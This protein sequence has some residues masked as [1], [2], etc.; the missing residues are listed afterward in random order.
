MIDELQALRLRGYTLLVIIGWACAAWMLILGAL[1]KSPDTL[2]A[3]LM[4]VAA[5][6][7]PTLMWRQRRVDSQARMAI[8]T[9][10]AIHPALA[11]WLWSGHAFQMDTHMYFFVALSALAVLC[12]WRPIALASAMIALHHAFFAI[13]APDVVFTADSSIWR[14]LVHAVA[15][16]LELA[17]LSYITTRMRQ[18]FAQQHEAR[19]QS[20]ALAAEA[21]ARRRDLERAME[22]ARAAGARAADERAR[23]EQVEAEARARHREDLHALAEAFSASVAEVVTSVGAAASQLEGSARSLNTLALETSRQTAQTARTAGSTAGNVSQLADQV[24]AISVSITAI[25]AAVEQQAQLSGTASDV[26]Q[27]G[28]DTVRAL[29]SQTAS[30][31]SFADRIQAIAGRTNLLAL[32][33]TIE[34]ARTGEAGQGFAVVAGEVKQLARQARDATGEIRS[35]AGTVSEG[36]IEVTAALAGIADMVDEV[37]Q[38]AH[39]IR[40]EV[41]SQ[42]ETA[43]AIDRTAATTAEHVNAMAGE[44]ERVAE[45]AAQTESLSNDVLGAAST[46]LE[47]A[48]NLRHAT[49]QFVGKLAA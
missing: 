39:A 16:I 26:S 41:S 21:N 46:L 7:V 38:A 8:G 36:A 22:E 37:A 30:I 43:K 18:L 14:V 47:A 29:A 33:A 20:E 31:T 2:T 40:N 25:L 19:Q 12:D 11:V 10:A 48:T 4:A 35:L 1:L 42:R 3:F 28:H 15:V 13:F 27:A 5:N 23:R 34:A 24:R 6:I 17:M 44:V 9:L 32:N 45:V 49:D